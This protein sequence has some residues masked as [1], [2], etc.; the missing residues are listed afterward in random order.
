MSEERSARMSSVVGE[1]GTV[2]GNVNGSGDLEVRGRVQGA[3]Y[4]DGRV[5]VTESGVVQGGIEATHITV[6]GRVQ[7]DLIASDSVMVGAFGRVEGNL[8]APRIGIEAG[9]R[10]RGILR[11]GDEE[12]A[13]STERREPTRTAAAVE[14]SAERA[15]P[16]RAP[17]ERAPLERAQEVRPSVDAAHPADKTREKRRPRR[18]KKPRPPLPTDATQASAVSHAAP[19]REQSDDANQ[20]R[21]RPP[22]KTLGQDST[23]AKRSAP[24][25]EA[26]EAISPPAKKKTRKRGAPTMPTFVKGTKGHKR[27]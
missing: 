8:S 10:V 19:A 9:A 17:P 11:A 13:P 25:A 1:A 22:K 23:P 6:Q 20:I 15:P 5:L 24:P 21:L 27:G 16:E 26:V 2:L 3:I 7:G 4:L 18:P 12:E 14:R